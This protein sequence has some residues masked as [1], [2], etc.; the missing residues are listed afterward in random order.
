MK[1]ILGSFFYIFFAIS[2][3]FADDYYFKASVLKKEAFVNEALLLQVDFYK[4]IELGTVVGVFKPKSN[5]FFE[6]KEYEISSKSTKEYAID[7]FKYIVKPKKEGRHKLSLLGSVL[8]FSSEDIVG[9]SNHRDAMPISATNKKE[10]LIDE[11]NF[12]IKK[13]SKQ[14]VGEFDI[15]IEQ[16]EAKVVRNEPAHFE[17]MVEGIGDISDLKLPQITI[18]NVKI[19]E[20]EPIQKEWIED[21]IL[22]GKI[23]KEFAVVSEKSFEIPSLEI[24][25][26][27]PKEAKNITKKTD[28]KKTEVALDE[29]FQDSLLDSK[30]EE[31]TKEFVTIEETKS[32]IFYLFLV[33]FG[34]FLGKI[35]INIQ[36]S[37]K[38]NPIKEKIKNA[39]NQKELLLILL[40][41]VE[42]EKAKNIIDILENSEIK[43]KK[44]QE[45]K[46]SA[47][48]IFE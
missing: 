34:F 4:K 5:E 21:G 42:N 15:K 40:P 20:Q 43:G 32:Y 48:V 11:I 19:F 45:A 47:I 17:L 29:G 6:F 46:N 14:A 28:I 41:Y 30:Q 26:F 39:K 3:I 37:K 2:A 25:Y 1:K 16:S 23:S 31:E 13:N 18:E 7:E 44:F 35:K 27:S 36:K 12:D 33:V 24:E 38:Q 22:H 8:I 10:I 9:S